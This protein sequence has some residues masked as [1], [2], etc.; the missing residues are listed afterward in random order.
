MNA[1]E[2]LTDQLWQTARALARNAT[3]R[4]VAPTD[5]ERLPSMTE[6][7]RDGLPYGVVGLDAT[8]IVLVFNRTE[9]LLTGVSP[10][11]AVGRNFFTHVAPCTN[12]RLF[13]G[14][15]ENGLKAEELDHIFPYTF[16]YKMRPTPVMVHL[17]RHRPSKTNW[18]LIKR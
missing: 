10:A 2:H 6:A 17:Y 13:K 14:C 4:F 1:H 11:Q 16:T 15:F 18:V 12:N 3:N 7:E 5:L 9:T 8:G